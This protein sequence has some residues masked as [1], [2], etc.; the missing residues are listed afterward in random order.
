MRAELL[1]E[2]LQQRWQ[3]EQQQSKHAKAKPNSNWWAPFA[4]AARRCAN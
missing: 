3:Q 1:H 4:K 2:E